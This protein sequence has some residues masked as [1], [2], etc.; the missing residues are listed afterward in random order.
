MSSDDVAQRDPGELVFQL[1]P[2]IDS[3]LDGEMWFAATKEVT[4]V[5]LTVL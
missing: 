3:S 1:L 4:N 5:E 2:K